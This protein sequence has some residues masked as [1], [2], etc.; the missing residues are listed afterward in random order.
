MCKM[1]DNI[2]GHTELLIV[3]QRLVGDQ[4]SV[5]RKS[6]YVCLPD[7][8]LSDSVLCIIFSLFFIYSQYILCYILFGF[9]S[10]LL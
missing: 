4:R 2:F 3:I 8:R 1:P 6:R 10:F 5:A 9:W 7:V